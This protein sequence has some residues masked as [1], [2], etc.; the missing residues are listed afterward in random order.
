MPG[1]RNFEHLPLI[2]REQGRAKLT[3][4]GNPS[5]QTIANRNA[6]QATALP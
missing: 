3:G 1:Q 2:L 6:R 4:G 5:P